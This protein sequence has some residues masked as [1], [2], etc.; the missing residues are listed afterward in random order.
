MATTPVVRSFDLKLDFPGLRVVDKN[1]TTA[2]CYF[3]YE[4]TKRQGMDFVITVP[5]DIL[6]SFDGPVM[7]FP[8]LVYD[9][10]ALRPHYETA[11]CDTIELRDE[12]GHRVLP[13][14]YPIKFSVSR[15]VLT[16]KGKVHVWHPTK[17]DHVAGRRYT[18]YRLQL[19]G[20]GEV[21]HVKKIAFQTVFSRSFTWQVKPHNGTNTLPA[22][23]D[24]I[25][26]CEDDTGIHEFVAQISADQEG[27]LAPAPARQDYALMDDPG[28]RRSI[29]SQTLAWPLDQMAGDDESDSSREQPRPRKPVYRARVETP[30]GSDSKHFAAAHSLAAISG[31]QNPAPEMTGAT[32]MRQ[33]TVEEA[34]AYAGRRRTREEYEKPDIPRSFSNGFMPAGGSVYEPPLPS[35]MVRQPSMEMQPIHPAQ[36]LLQ[37]MEG[38]RKISDASISRLAV[39]LVYSLV[40]RQPHLLDGEAL[41]TLNTLNHTHPELDKVLSIFRE[42]AAPQ[43]RL[44]MPAAMPPPPLVQYQ[45]Y[46][47]PLPTPSDGSEY[48]YAKMYMGRQ[49]M[50]PQPMMRTGSYPLPYPGFPMEA[51]PRPD[52]SADMNS[53]GPTRETG[54]L[55][56]RGF[57]ISGS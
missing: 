41:A 39:V 26:T 22:P 2:P 8:R 36:H 38:D 55:Y 35:P 18:P 32:L 28:K 45:P 17:R 19:I 23:A 49:A 12:T 27:S 7:L 3:A 11:T 16:C 21:N 9:D 4:K 30:G 33:P 31:H 50:M 43:H 37:L 44:P 14:T 53:R 34:A 46:P 40:K 29:R 54:F 10:E 56:P 13:P 25:V 15:D 57:N 20:V 6:E 48:D 51:Y 24:D 52:N 42:V 5:E 47:G 1:I